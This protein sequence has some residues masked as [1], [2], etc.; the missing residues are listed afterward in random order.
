ML[1]VSQREPRPAEPPAAQRGVLRCRR[2]CRARLGDRE[3]QRPRGD[4]GGAHRQQRA[5]GRRRPRRAPT[6]RG[7][8]GT[9]RTQARSTP[10]PAAPTRCRRRRRDGGPTSARRRA[11][12]LETAVLRGD[13]DAAPALVDAVIAAGTPVGDVIGARADAGDPAS[14]RRLRPRRGVPAADDDRRRGDEGRRRAR[15]G[16]HCRRARVPRRGASCSRP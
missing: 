8:R 4:G 5:C 11:T 13:A 14:R 12:A 3:P 1:G 10:R 9:P 6:R 7:R 15:Q 2:R 16:A